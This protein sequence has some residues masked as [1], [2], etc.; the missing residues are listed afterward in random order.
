MQVSEFLPGMDHVEIAE[1]PNTIL[2][3]VAR[4]NSQLLAG[5]PAFWSD[6]YSKGILKKLAELPANDTES[7]GR[8]ERRLPGKRG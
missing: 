4:R 3:G 5:A 2:I 8:L 6:C 7:F 1:M